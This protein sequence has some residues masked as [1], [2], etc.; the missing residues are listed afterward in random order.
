MR[1][2]M[3]KSRN[4]QRRRNQRRKREEGIDKAGRADKEMEKETKKVNAV[5]EEG[6]R[7]Q[8]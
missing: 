6:R 2:F 3:R 1:K 4:K 7:N 8:N 5:E